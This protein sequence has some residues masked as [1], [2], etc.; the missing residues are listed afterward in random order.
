M[1][2]I[3]TGLTWNVLAVDKWISSESWWARANRIVIDNLAQSICSTS[4]WTRIMT[5]LVD[6]SLVQGTIRTLQ[7]FRLAVRRFSKVTRLAFTHWSWS[8]NGAYGVWT[9]RIRVARSRLNWWLFWFWKIINKIS[10]N[11]TKVGNTDF[12]TYFWGNIV[13]KDL[14]HNLEYKYKQLDE[15]QLGTQRWHRKCLD[16]DPNTFD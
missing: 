13:G 7:T 3:K 8:L 15:W 5:L 1:L 11:L 4:S 12:K 16:K 10:S 9:A 2:K 14:L 6:T